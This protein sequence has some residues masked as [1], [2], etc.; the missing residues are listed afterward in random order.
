MNEVDVGMDITNQHLSRNFKLLVATSAISRSGVAGF[1]LAV[2]WIALLLTRSSI[3]AGLADGMAVLPLF[4]SF[5][6]GAYVDRLATKKGLAILVSLARVLSIFGLFIALLVKG[7]LIE[8]LSIYFVAFVIGLSTD[9]MNSTSASWTKQFL[10]SQQYKSGVSLSQSLGAVAEGV[11]YALSGVFLI[12]G[13][14]FAVYSFA[15]VFSVAIIPILLMK[16]ERTTIVSSES[17]MNSSV[18]K[19]LEYVF[20]DKRL[21]GLVMIV[22]AINLALGTLGIFMAFLIQ[23]QFKLSAIYFTTLALSLTAGVILG[24]VLGSTAK[25]KLGLYSI[26]TILPIGFLLFLVGIIRSV[27]PD[28]AITFVIGVL[29]G[30]INVVINTAIL[31]IVDQ[32]MMGRVSGVIKTFGISLTFLSGTIGGILIQVLTLQGGFYLIGA[33]VCIISFTPVAFREFYNLML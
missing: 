12:L 31:K 32:E 7:L 17:N 14:N 19:G 13:L 6:L 27:F 4:F 2:I 20:K 11:G 24:S 26:G 18:R 30:V 29:I 3:L 10:G 8:T 15:V 5:I 1:Q 25:G 23:D 28:F 33:I 21:R 16:D 9:V 22:L